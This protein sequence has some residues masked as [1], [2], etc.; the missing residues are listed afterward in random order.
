MD[1]GSKTEYKQ[2]L[3]GV[4]M[5]ASTIRSLGGRYPRVSSNETVTNIKPGEDGQLVDK[6]VSG[7]GIRK[8]NANYRSE[9]GLEFETGTE[10][11]TGP[12]D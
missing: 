9:S 10:R 8:G 1:N 12:T 11:S 7:M 5:R 3:E 6:G 2:S 4:V